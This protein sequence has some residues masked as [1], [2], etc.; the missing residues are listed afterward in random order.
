MGAL[1]G[2]GVDE[3]SD[4]P[5]AA[6][7]STP[8]TAT[9][10]N[11]S[12]PFNRRTGPLGP[13]CKPLKN[14]A[15]STPILRFTKD[16]PFRF[17]AASPEPHNLLGRKQAIHRARSQQ[18]VVERRRNTDVAYIQL[19]YVLPLPSLLQPQLGKR[20]RECGNGTDRWIVV[21][22]AR[23]IKASRRIQR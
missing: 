9:A 8:A 22:P 20:R 1:V 19:A 21:H 10:D 15:L 18:L 4:P 6:S 7:T 23:R 16:H 13:L 17:T 12:R 2:V 3:S 11:P 14:I 5:H